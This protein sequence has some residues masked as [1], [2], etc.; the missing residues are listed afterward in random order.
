[1]LVDFVKLGTPMA[2]KFA[3]VQVSKLFVNSFIN[4]YGVVVSAFA[5]IANKLA[6]VVILFSNA[7]NTAGSTMVGQNIAAGK[8]DRVR[9]ILLD[10]LVITMIF[11]IIFSALI[12]FFPREIFALFVEDG[13]TAVLDLA[14]GYVPIALLMFLAASLHSSCDMTFLS[15]ECPNSCC[16]AC[17]IVV[18]IVARPLTFEF[19]IT[20]SSCFDALDKSYFSG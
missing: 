12:I 19:S 13:E 7:M 5:G 16:N 6:S 14:P 8:F 15:S 3:S 11:A 18:G 9:R 10:L 1:M 20:L 4:A 2:I 17:S